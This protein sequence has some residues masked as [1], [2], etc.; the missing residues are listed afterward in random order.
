MFAPRNSSPSPMNGEEHAAYQVGCFCWHSVPSLAG[1]QISN[2]W[3]LFDKH[4]FKIPRNTSLD[5]KLCEIFKSFKYNVFKLAK[6]LSIKLEL[7]DPRT[8]YL[9]HG[10]KKLIKVSNSNKIELFFTKMFIGLSTFFSVY[11]GL[12]P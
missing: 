11:F 8:S 12:T 10:S 9:I 3:H 7:C 5:M 2:I 4:Q 6:N 1:F